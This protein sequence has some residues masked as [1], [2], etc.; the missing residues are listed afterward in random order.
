MP[1]SVWF[2]QAGR[3]LN[4]FFSECFCIFIK[5]IY[6][7]NEQNRIFSLAAIDIGLSDD[8]RS[9]P[10]GSGALRMPKLIL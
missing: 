2:L 3:S 5:E 10:D 4:R 6:H 7:E 9:I 1:V 8:R